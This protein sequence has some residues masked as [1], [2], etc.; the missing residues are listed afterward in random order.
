[1]FD[2]CSKAGPIFGGVPDNK[3]ISLI[4]DKLG[5]EISYDHEV[6]KLRKSDANHVIIFH[7]NANVNAFGEIENL[8]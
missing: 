1:M 6:E 3:A 2:I 8:S 4:F 5:I 7:S